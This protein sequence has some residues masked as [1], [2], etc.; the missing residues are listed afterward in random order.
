MIEFI[1]CLSLPER[2]VLSISPE[3]KGYSL[4]FMRVRFIPTWNRRT[5]WKILLPLRSVLKE[6][7]HRYLFLIE[8][9]IVHSFTPITISTTQGKEE[10]NEGGNQKIQ[11]PWLRAAPD[12][13][14]LW[15]GGAASPAP[16]GLWS[17]SALHGSRTAAEGI[18]LPHV[19]LQRPWRV[20]HT[21]L[22]EQ[23]VLLCPVGGSCPFHPRWRVLA[24][25]VQ[26]PRRRGRAFSFGRSIR[27]FFLPVAAVMCMYCCRHTRVTRVP[28]AR[29]SIVVWPG[30]LYVFYVARCVRF[31]DRASYSWKQTSS[32]TNLFS[33]PRLLC[34][35][36]CRNSRDP[37]DL[38]P[39]KW[40]SVG[41]PSEYGYLRKFTQYAKYRK[42]LDDAGRA[43]PK[44]GTTRLVS[45]QKPLQRSPTR[46]AAR[47][48]GQLPGPAGR[49][50][51]RRLGHV[52][53]TH[54][55]G[56][57]GSG[58]GLCPEI[59]PGAYPVT[60]DRRLTIAGGQLAVDGEGGATVFIS[61]SEAVDGD[62]P[63]RARD[64][65]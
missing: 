40:M 36:A 46:G 61:A 54:L 15:A 48:H 45:L 3:G 59:Q 49:C 28:R 57:S 12:R 52:S 42:I 56:R 8:E 33:S 60:D 10:R 31:Q 44:N 2:S 55:R 25:N 6:S 65:S 13:R 16:P 24:L 1:L 37:C 20:A 5:S 26:R 38:W 47:G 53:V 30:R 41:R 64:L 51:T 63:R 21:R 50:L 18:V 39:D 23:I 22:M 43:R 4:S 17:P 35:C 7:N 11:V 27:P 62:G 32:P 19:K 29:S 9:S 14:E 34:C 58:C